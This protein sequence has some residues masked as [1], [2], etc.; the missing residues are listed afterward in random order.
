M[1]FA[2]KSSCR[3]IQLLFHVMENTLLLSQRVKTLKQYRQVFLFHFGAQH[4]ILPIVILLMPYKRT[5]AVQSPLVVPRYRAWPDF[6]KPLPWHPNIT[7]FNLQRVTT[8]SLSLKF[9]F[10]IDCFIVWGRWHGY[11]YSILRVT[12][13]PMDHLY[14]KRQ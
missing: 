2:K 6:W 7:S 8:H 5:K 1:L 13:S 11:I 9:S 3:K 12:L 4:F 14:L 10:Y